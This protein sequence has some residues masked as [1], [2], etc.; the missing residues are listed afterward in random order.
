LR[1]IGAIYRAVPH[2]L[3]C[4]GY[5]PFT[6]TLRQGVYATLFP[7]ATESLWTFVNRTNIEIDGDQ[8]EVP[9]SP[10]MKFYDLWRGKELTPRVD[11]NKA[12]LAFAM[13]P[14][15][16][17]AVLSTTSRLSKPAK[18]LLSAMRRRA[19]IRL[20]NLSAEWN[21]LTQQMVEI[22][23]TRPASRMPEGMVRIPAARFNFKVQGLWTWETKGLDVQYP[24]ETEPT[25]TH[26][27]AMN[28]RAFYI[29]KTPATC[30]QF[31]QFLDATH[32]RPKD[33]HN[34]L[35]DWT[36]G[37]FPEGWAKKPV[38]WVSL[39]DA[40]A[41]A[42]W[43]GKRLPHEWEWQYAA[44]GTDG[45]LYPW[46]NEKDDSRVPPFDQ[47]RDQRPPTDVDAYPQGASPFGVLDLV[48]NVWQWTD[49][50]QDV[51][52]RAAIVRGGSYYRPAGSVY[53]FPQ[54]R[55]LDE[56]GK[57]WLLADSTDR[58]ATI[59]FRCVVDAE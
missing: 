22:P 46:G 41:Y 1:R 24:W 10:G 14:R 35:R 40:R 16:F 26:K 11:G 19:D 45:R 48:G 56:H 27:H 6:P 13:E 9:F 17:G 34:F 42:K 44:Q 20:A 31:K 2:L 51:H 23:R 32:Y 49:E 39:D 54:A 33:S 28:I 37:E 59:G 8:I 47:T 4:P 25:R 7:G 52:N 12:V 30:A 58:S 43:A 3:I 5:E 55:R 57:Y 53:Y 36:R 15:G 38:T 50:F 21:V 29:D 18:R